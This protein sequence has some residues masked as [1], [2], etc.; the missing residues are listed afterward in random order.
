M[1]RRP[2]VATPE[3][4][5]TEITHKQ[6]H[7]KA[8]EYGTSSEHFVL[9]M[10]KELH[11]STKMIAQNSPSGSTRVQL[12][13]GFP[14][15]HSPQQD[16]TR[17]RPR[18]RQDNDHEHDYNQRQPQTTY[19]NSCNRYSREHEFP[20]HNNSSH[21]GKRLHDDHT[22][23]QHGIGYGSTIQQTLRLVGGGLDDQPVT[24]RNQG[25]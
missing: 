5:I 3:Y 15:I 11:F 8:V 12:C 4:L 18:L 19:V 10:L 1:A 25:S 9:E 13:W 7:G 6:S 22:T 14:H 20:Q 16:S 2:C 17:P 21:A 23:T 24:Q